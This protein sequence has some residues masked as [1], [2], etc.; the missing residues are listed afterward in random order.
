MLIYVQILTLSLVSVCKHVHF[1]NLFVEYVCSSRLQVQCHLF[2]GFSGTF[3]STVRQ[4]LIRESI[5][6]RRIT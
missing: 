2:G 3:S 6:L 4:K 1:L 5:R